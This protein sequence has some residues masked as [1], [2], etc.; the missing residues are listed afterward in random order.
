[1]S[2]G[3]LVSCFYCGALNT[4]VDDHQGDACCARCAS[5]IWQ[6]P[7]ANLTLTLSLTVAALILYIPANV[8][9][10]LSIKQLGQY[11]ESTILGGVGELVASGMWGIGIV[12]FVAS[13]LVPLLKI[14]GLIYLCWVARWGRQ[15]A[16]Q[17]KAGLFIFKLVHLT[18]P[19]SMLDVFVVAILVSLVKFG[20][21]A[22]IMP[23]PGLV[24]FAA[25]VV[26]T[27]LASQI[28]DP[29]L[30]WAPAFQPDKDR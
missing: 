28:F 3:H 30:M 9:P 16:S 20:E 1:M 24:A 2:D 6:R 7:G 11:S 4:I 17:R 27:L 8:F 29:R 15:H 25:V 23:G 12:V 26:L 19:W 13:I 5:K 10:I 14:G 18:G 21:L 22:T